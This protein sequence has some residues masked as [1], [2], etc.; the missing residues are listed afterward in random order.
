MTG[1]S[2]NHVFLFKK[3]ALFSLQVTTKSSHRVLCLLT[4]LGPKCVTESFCKQI[5]FVFS[6]F[7]LFQA[8]KRPNH[9]PLLCPRFLSHMT[10]R[11][12]D[13][14]PP[15][16]PSSGSRPLPPPREKTAVTHALA[17]PKTQTL[18]GE[19]YRLNTC[20][21]HTIAAPTGGGHGLFGLH[22]AAH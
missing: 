19:A 22:R 4:I 12:E 6:F 9:G 10:A 2:S 20:R 3:P 7:I 13:L 8:H 15:C 11:P 1:G 5:Y 16:V 21:F 17:A 18:D 14:R